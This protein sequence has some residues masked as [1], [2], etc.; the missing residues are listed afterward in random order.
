M[1]EF[2][3]IGMFAGLGLIGYR[4]NWFEK[5]CIALL[6]ADERVRNA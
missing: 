1:I 4:S 5:I 6:E 3:I 2:I